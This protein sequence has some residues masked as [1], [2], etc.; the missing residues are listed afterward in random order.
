MESYTE[1]ENNFPQ[2]IQIT[3]SSSSS[4]RNASS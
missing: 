4:A 3:Y 1:G 2:G